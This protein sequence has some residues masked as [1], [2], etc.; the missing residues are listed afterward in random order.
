[1][2][3]ES[4]TGPM[5]ARGW[6]F[7]LVMLPFLVAFS[8]AFAAV[9]MAWVACDVYGKALEKVGRCMT[10]GFIEFATYVARPFGVVNELEVARQSREGWPWDCAR[11]KVEN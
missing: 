10:A 11:R 4:T 2:S 6:L 3:K 9:L 8:F 1:M 7:L 5:T